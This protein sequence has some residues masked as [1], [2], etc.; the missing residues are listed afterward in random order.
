MLVNILTE[1]NTIL[2]LRIEK[3]VDLEQ[4]FPDST[5]SYQGSVLDLNK[6]PEAQGL[7]DDVT[8]SVASHNTLDG[9]RAST[10]PFLEG[11]IN[12]YKCLF[13]FD[14]GADVSCLPNDVAIDLGLDNLIEPVKEIRI[15]GIGETKV[16]GRVNTCIWIDE[17]S[18]PI[19]LTVAQLN[20]SKS[21]ILIGRDLMIKYG[22]CLN[23]A[24][25]TISIQNKVFSMLNR[26]QSSDL[27]KPIKMV[28][29]QSL[30]RILEN[31]IKNPLQ[32]KYRI[33]KSS[34]Q[35]FKQHLSCHAS[36]LKEIGF[37]EKNGTYLYDR[38]I[39][40]LTA[41]LGCS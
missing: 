17:T 38:P 15:G 16:T 18:Y 29:D 34:S 10:Q 5:F 21:L 1:E 32:D 22:V 37:V 3:L 2:P 4:Y 9:N 26:D 14:S 11:L 19:S 20:V 7:T 41:Y 8:I 13:L 28:T 33:L 31:I 12:G 6:S 23:F 24:N 39:D 40:K 35:Y 25:R 36:F 30:K 27:E